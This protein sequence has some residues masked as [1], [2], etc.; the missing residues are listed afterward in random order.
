MKHYFICKKNRP[1]LTLFFAGWGMDERPFIDYEPVENDLLM[2]YDYRSMEFDFSVLRGYAGIRLVGWSMGVWVAAYTVQYARLPITESIAVNGTLI[3]IDASKGIPF[4]V[5]EGTLREL[6]E[7]TLK[8]FRRRMCVSGK[9]L[10]DFL[11]KAPRRSV[12]ELKEEL[13]LIGE[14]VVSLPIP[15][16]IWEKAVTGREDLIFTPA[17]QRNAWKDTETEQAELDIPHYSEKTLRELLCV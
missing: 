11:E 9:M 12:E 2:C 10:E 17:N 8:K 13:R 4:P 16:F 14:R 7:R 6:N 5:F 15:D 1:T 3:P